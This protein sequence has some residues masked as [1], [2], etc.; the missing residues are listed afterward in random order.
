MLAPPAKQAISRDILRLE[1]ALSDTLGMT[2]QVQT[3]RQGP[4]DA[5]FFQ[6]DE[7]QGLLEKLGIPL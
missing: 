4:P 5:E 3:N 1:E 7:L 6:P 2:A